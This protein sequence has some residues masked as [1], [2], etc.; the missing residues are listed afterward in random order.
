MYGVHGDNYETAVFLV[1]CRDQGDPRHG[2]VFSV[3]N[4]TVL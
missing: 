1:N 4:G 3:L 2:E